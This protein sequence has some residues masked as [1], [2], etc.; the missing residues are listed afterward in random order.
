ML[1]WPVTV[2]SRGGPILEMRVALIYELGSATLMHEPIVTPWKHR[3]A[4][5]Q[6]PDGL[7]ITLFQVLEPE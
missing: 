1:N 6:S 5:L 2:H 7:Q 3:N 4:R